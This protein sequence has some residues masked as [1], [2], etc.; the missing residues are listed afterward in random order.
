MKKVSLELGRLAT[1]V[2]SSIQYDDS[3]TSLKIKYH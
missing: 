3:L 2:A 1:E